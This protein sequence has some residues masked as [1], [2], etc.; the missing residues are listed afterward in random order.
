MKPTILL[1]ALLSPFIGMAQNPAEP[2]SDK[3][4]EQKGKI[5]VTEKNKDETVPDNPGQSFYWGFVAAHYDSHTNI[6]YAMYRRSVRGL[7]KILAQIR[8]DDIEGNHIA[9]YSGVW[10]STHKGTPAYSKPS[11]CEVNGTSC[12]SITEFDDLLRKFIPEFKKSPAHGPV[13]G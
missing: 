11:E 7:G 3:V 4:C 2:M 6:C 5:Y 9:G 13:D 12:D 8:I 1:L 10:V